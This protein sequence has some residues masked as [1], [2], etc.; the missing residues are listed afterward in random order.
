MPKPHVDHRSKNDMLIDFIEELESLF[1]S[2][3][4]T[5][6]DVEISLDSAYCVQKVLKALFDARLRVITCAN[7]TW[8]GHKFNF[9]S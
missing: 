6:S 1:V 2:L 5:L 7:Y 8:L 9:F 3:G 4:K